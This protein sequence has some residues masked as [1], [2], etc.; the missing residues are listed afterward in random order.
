MYLHFDVINRHSLLLSVSVILTTSSNGNI[1]RGTGPLCRQFIGDRPVT[2]SF[3]AFFY[4]YTNKMLR[5]QSWGW[6]L[7]RHRAHY[8]VT[9]MIFRK[10]STQPEAWIMLIIILIYDSDSKLVWFLVLY[11][12][13]PFPNL[14]DA[15]VEVWEWHDKRKSKLYNGQF[16]PTFEKHIFR[17]WRDM[18]CILPVQD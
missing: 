12:I 1:F 6:Y 4:L 9:A 10:C 14:N 17:Y 16:H 15:T 3:D 13:H 18:K 5:A 8:D 11:I 7:R 2:W